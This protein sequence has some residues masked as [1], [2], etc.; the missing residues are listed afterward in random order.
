MKHQP[1]TCPECGE[2]LEDIYE[3]HYETY[4]FNAETNSYDDD[5]YATVKCG[6]CE[7]DLRGMPEFECGA[8]NYQASVEGQR[9][10]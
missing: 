4:T 3:T 9:E 6:F 5:G 7:A 10:P 2:P 8:C 1:P